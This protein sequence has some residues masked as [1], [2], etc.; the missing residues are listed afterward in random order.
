M[1][2]AEHFYVPHL[3][4]REFS[5]AAGA[6]WL[7]KLSGWSLIQIKNGSGYW[8]QA[9]SSKELET[10]SVLFVAGSFAGSIRASQLNTMALTLF[11][12]IPQRLIGLIT[13]GELNYLKRAAGGKDFALRVLAPTHPVAVKMHELGIEPKLDGLMLRL[14]LL[15]L[16]VESLGNELRP[17]P[18][19][20]NISD[21]KERLE[22]FLR[23]TPP[24]ELLDIS[25][26]ELA[27]KT[28]CTSRHLSRIFNELIGMSFREKRAE[29]RLARACELLATS[30][31][32]VVEVAMESGYKSLSLFNLM[33][34]RRFGTS[35]GKWR[36]K[37]ASPETIQLNRNR[38]KAPFPSFAGSARTSAERAANSNS[39]RPV[40]MPVS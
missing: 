18:G 20:E 33:F 8:L 40:G 21:A 15:E 16:F 5:V 38:T 17:S 24:D 39:Q 6:D 12:V 26:K 34:T 36:K 37:Q 9:N 35:P 4:F 10:G 7:P 11:T 28:H 23:D 22:T 27:R 1:K 32:K 19:G 31:S 30:Q 2:K 13:L 14:K 3:T 29:I 25:F